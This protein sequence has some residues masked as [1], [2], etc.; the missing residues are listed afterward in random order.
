MWRLLLKVSLKALTE[1]RDKQRGGLSHSVVGSVD[2]LVFF[3]SWWLDCEPSLGSSASVLTRRNLGLHVHSC[4]PS[5]C[6]LHLQLT[7]IH[8]DA[9]PIPTRVFPFFNS[10]SLLFSSKCSAH[11]R[12]WVL[13]VI[14]DIKCVTGDGRIIIYKEMKLQRQEEWHW[15][16]PQ[17]WRWDVEAYSV[18]V[19][20]LCQT[21]LTWAETLF[22]WL[23]EDFELNFLKENKNL[24]EM[25]FFYH[26]VLPWNTCPQTKKRG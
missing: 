14:H 24:L 23:L 17:V 4:Q 1:R 7:I 19:F 9:S 10:H 3:F 22:K 11:L 16:F 25:Y 21:I 12:F 6:L 2:V 13:V 8:R 18:K 26:V 15:Y 5:Q 20:P